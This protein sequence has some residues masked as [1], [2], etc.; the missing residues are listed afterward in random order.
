MVKSARQAEICG[1]P[2]R[3]PLDLERTRCNCFSVGAAVPQEKE[4]KGRGTLQSS[5][6]YV[7]SLHSRQGCRLSHKSFAISSA[8]CS[9]AETSLSAETE[10][11]RSA[12][13]FGLHER[14]GQHDLNCVQMEMDLSSAEKWAAYS[15][16]PI[17]LHDQHLTLEQQ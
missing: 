9:L 7:S 16:L 4:W 17:R 15:M 14:Q 8:Q 13:C 11:T 1:D 5:A 12:K 6:L 3:T 10:L 2:C